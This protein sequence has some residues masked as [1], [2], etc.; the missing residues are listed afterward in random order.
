MN[1]SV[2]NSEHYKSFFKSITSDK[3]LVTRLNAMPDDYNVAV[4]DKQALVEQ[5]MH[6]V[7]YCDYLR[8]SS[9]DGNAMT[10]LRNALDS[11][12]G[13]VYEKLDNLHKMN[14]GLGL[15]GGGDAAEHI[16]NGA[17]SHKLFEEYMKNDEEDP[18]T[19]EELKE[20][21]LRKF[22]HLSLSPEY[23]LKYSEYAAVRS[24]MFHSSINLSRLDYETKC[25]A[26]MDE[27]LRGNYSSV[28]E[29]ALAVCQKAE[30]QTVSHAL[31]TGSIS[32]KTADDIIESVAVVLLF[33]VLVFGFAYEFYFA[34]AITAVASFVL[35]VY[36]DI[37]SDHIHMYAAKR[38]YNEIAEFIAELNDEDD[39]DSDFVCDYDM[40][41]D[42]REVTYE[43]PF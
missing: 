33:A 18:A 14:F 34:A 1:Q 31:V 11:C 6:S 4:E 22:S 38:S 15:F 10:V 29:A 41:H 39:S 7:A 27:F 12:G 24:D 8:D 13:T 5:C 23:I 35:Y 21:I 9:I 2:F 40:Y 17:D 37:I 30:I 42:D 20:E 36:P 28:A 3:D 43:C 19:E 16:V 25:V 26:A 32:K